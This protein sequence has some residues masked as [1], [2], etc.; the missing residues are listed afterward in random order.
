MSSETAADER[1][2]TAPI[3][4]R[5]RAGSRGS[6]AAR[7]RAARSRARSLEELAEE[8]KPTNNGQRIAL[9]I[10]SIIGDEAEVT[11][12]RITAE[13]ERMT[14]RVPVNVAASV[15]QAA[16]AGLVDLEG[17]TGTRL[18]PAGEQYVTGG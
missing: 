10:A 6:A 7:S 18:T 1:T 8:L 14:W 4:S 9:A 12:A 16:R 2:G 13:F 5:T 17:P 11:A 15:R 3:A